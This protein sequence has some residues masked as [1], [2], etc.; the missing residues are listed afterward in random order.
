MARAGEL[1]KQVSLTRL[2]RLLGPKVLERLQLAALREEAMGIVPATPDEL[3]VAA[4]W[5]NGDVQKGDRHGVRLRS[6]NRIVFTRM[7][8]KY[9]RERP[10]AR[11]NFSRWCR[12]TAAAARK[13]AKRGKG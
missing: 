5:I 9:F 1:G 4:A 13:E 12:E 6:R 2:S 8:T 11:T 10:Q 7:A 3:E